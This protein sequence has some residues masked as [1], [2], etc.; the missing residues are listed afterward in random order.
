MEDWY[1]PPEIEAK[2]KEC[3]DFVSSVEG[4]ALTLDAIVKELRDISGPKHRFAR[5]ELELAINHLNMAV[6]ILNDAVSREVSD[7]IKEVSDD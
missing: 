4:N 7:L 1:E 5:M 6:L 3:F 2:R